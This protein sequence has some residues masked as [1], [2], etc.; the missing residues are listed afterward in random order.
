[1]VELIGSMT[2]GLIV[3]KLGFSIQAVALFVFMMAMLMLAL[4]DIDVQLLPNCITI[5]LIWLDDVNSPKSPW[6]QT[7]QR[8]DIRGDWN[9]II[10]SPKPPYEPVQESRISKPLTLERG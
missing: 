3:W 2:L 9:Q 1:M 8:H 4:I 7:N 5:P 10:G 6:T